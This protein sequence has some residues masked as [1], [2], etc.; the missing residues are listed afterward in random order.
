MSEPGMVRPKWSTL[1]PSN[2]DCKETEE[3]K[4]LVQCF[5]NKYF[6]SVRR[7]TKKSISYTTQQFLQ[8]FQSK[9]LHNMK[10]EL[11]KNQNI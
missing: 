6:V 1:S 8:Q 11:I 3:E 7:R 4:K 2:C 9:K 10:K 5:Q